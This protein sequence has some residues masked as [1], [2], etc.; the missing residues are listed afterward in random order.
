[1]LADEMLGTPDMAVALAAA[2]LPSTWDTPAVAAATA[3]KDL[4]IPRCCCPWAVQDRALAVPQDATV[5]ADPQEATT[6]ADPEEVV[7]VGADSRE[8]TVAL[9]TAELLPVALE[10]WTPLWALDAWAPPSWELDPLALP[11]WAL[12]ARAPPSWELAPAE[13][14]LRHRSSI[15]LHPPIH[16]FGVSYF[17]VR[18]VIHLTTASQTVTCTH[19]MQYGHE[20]H[21]CLEVLQDT[22]LEWEEPKRGKSV[23][24][25]PNRGKAEYPQPRY[26]PAE[27][28]Y[29]LVPPLW[30]DCVSLPPP[31]AEGEYL[32]VPPPS[33]WED[34]VSLPPPLTEGEYLLVP[35]PWE[36]CVSLT[37]PPAE[38]EYLLVPPP[39]LW[40]VCVSL[41]PPPAEGEFLLVSPPPP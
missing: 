24:P 1:M 29:L 11:F 39:P 20:E 38:E 41:P 36:D 34:C 18:D 16:C 35:P 22:D 10:V 26:P 21:H 17:L 19:C 37:L 12:D 33:L 6:G 14:R 30:E 31:P 13:V 8:A 7:E 3:L 32:L 9:D 5:G 25:Q 28:E 15:Q 27:G 4:G 23:R 40:E 2:M